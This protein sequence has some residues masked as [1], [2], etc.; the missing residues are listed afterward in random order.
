[1]HVLINIKDLSVKETTESQNTR[2]SSEIKNLLSEQERKEKRTLHRLPTGN[3]RP[4]PGGTLQIHKAKSPG[5]ARGGRITREYV[6]PE[7]DHC[8]IA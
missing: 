1:M 8:F 4:S 7:E 5:S 6:G 3:I 2:L